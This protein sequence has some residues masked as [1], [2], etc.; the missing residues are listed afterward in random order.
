M[1]RPPAVTTTGKD[2][3][4]TRSTTVLLLLPVT[5][6]LEVKGGTGRYQAGTETTDGGAGVLE[7]LTETTT[8]ET[9]TETGTGTGTATGGGTA[10]TTG[11]VEGTETETI[12]M[13]GTA[14]TVEVSASADDP[15]CRGRPAASE[16]VVTLLVGLAD[17]RDSPTRSSLRPS[18]WLHILQVI[19]SQL[20]AVRS[21]QPR[22]TSFRRRRERRGGGEEGGG[23]SQAVRAAHEGVHPR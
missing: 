17:Y 6:S 14:A 16:E 7:T 13:G 1:H 8:V 22:T 21:N 18:G 2:E 9:E 5:A 3:T 4:M 23:A 10:T 19:R 11:A 15:I 12:E 20:A